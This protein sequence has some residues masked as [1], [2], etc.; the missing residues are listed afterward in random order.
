MSLPPQGEVQEADKCDL[1]HPGVCTF[2]EK[3]GTCKF[4]DKCIYL[5]R[6]VQLAMPAIGVVDAPKKTRKQG[7]G[8]SPRG[9]LGKDVGVS[10]IA[11]SLASTTSEARE[12]HTINLPS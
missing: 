6:E 1:K 12:L 7:R 8:G 4:G 10:A 9:E 5:H 11:C 2:W 3:G